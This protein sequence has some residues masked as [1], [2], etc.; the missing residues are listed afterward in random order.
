ME[1]EKGIQDREY[2][3]PECSG[4]DDSYGAAQSMPT[5]G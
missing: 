4:L 2:L 1:L 5:E 3:G